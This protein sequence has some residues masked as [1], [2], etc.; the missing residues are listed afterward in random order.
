M[1]MYKILLWLVLQ[2]YR[3]MLGILQQVNPLCIDSRVDGQIVLLNKI[4]P[5]GTWSRFEDM[6]DGFFLVGGGGGGVFYS[7]PCPLFQIGNMLQMVSVWINMNEG[8]LA[9]S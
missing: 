7:G 8:N 1:E 6:F 5:G 9:W 2:L 4:R 3:Q